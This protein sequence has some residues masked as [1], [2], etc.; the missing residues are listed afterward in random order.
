MNAAPVPGF[1]KE[2]PEGTVL[3]VLAAPR[4]SAN[5][6]GPVVDDMVRVRVTA[7]AADGAANAAIVKL[8]SDA[9]DIPKSRVRLIS[10]HNAKRKRILIEGLRPADVVTRLT[11][12]MTA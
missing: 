9:L 5:A 7:A 6:V 3:F 4:S 11:A 2:H 12:R 8:L 1:A 10:G